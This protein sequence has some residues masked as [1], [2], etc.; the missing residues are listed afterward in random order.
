[1][2]NL[3]RNELLSWTL[4]FLFSCNSRNSTAPIGRQLLSMTTT[5]VVPFL[6][7]KRNHLRDFPRNFAGIMDIQGFRLFTVLYFSVRST[8]SSA[9]RYGLLSCGSVKTTAINPDARPVG[10][11]ENRGP[12]LTVRRAIS[13]RSHEKIGDC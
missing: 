3:I 5:V 1:M 7:L 8:R 13:E 4:D 11:F 9:L 12:S 6:H 10:T 2:R